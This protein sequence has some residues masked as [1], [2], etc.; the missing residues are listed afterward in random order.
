MHIVGWYEDAHLV[1][2]AA[3]GTPRPRP[4]Y[5]DEAGFRLD[6]DGKKFSYSI[7]AHKAFLVL[8]EDRT[9]PISNSNI[10][11]S[12]YSYLLH[13]SETTPATA[14]KIE[15]LTEINQRLGVLR[16]V[17]VAQP[18]RENV[19]TD[20]EDEIDPLINF[21]TPEQRK[22][23]ELAAEDA[24]TSYLVKLGYN[25]VRRADEK[26]GYDLQ[27]I[28]KDGGQ[29]LY[30]E[31]K[32]TS[33]SISRFFMTPNERAFMTAEG[34]RFAL[35]TNAVNNPVIEFID[36]RQFETRF[37]LHPGVFVGKTKVAKAY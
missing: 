31:V 6:T 4:E 16:K 10:R 28:S 18:G 15:V 26:I 22:K 33:G 27:A 21:G 34:W 9:D 13:P 24:V 29:D 37:D 19:K 8:P 3:D 36:R 32:G 17:A 11:Q 7:V 25:V 30:V 1:G 2:K 5:E 20:V 23:V 14:T 12:S 35:V